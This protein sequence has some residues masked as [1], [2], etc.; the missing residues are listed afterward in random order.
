MNQLCMH[1]VSGPFVMLVEI[2]K[3][4]LIVVPL[5]P[6][7]S[8]EV[9]DTFFRVSPEYASGYIIITA[10]AT[11]GVTLLIMLPA[12]I[13]IACVCHRHALKKHNFSEKKL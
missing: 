12:V 1:Y 3:Q 4:C 11:F 13:I 10:V 5:S 6:S 8:A 9:S 2:V 7:L